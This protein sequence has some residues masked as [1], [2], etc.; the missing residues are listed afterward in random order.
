MSKHLVTMN[1]LIEDYAR[2]IDEQKQE[3]RQLRVALSQIAH[4]V[5][6]AVLPT[7]SLQFITEEVEKEVELVVT[8]LRADNEHLRKRIEKLCKNNQRD[9]FLELKEGIDDLEKRRLKKD[10]DVHGELE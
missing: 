9:F 1:E 5:G 2:I 6:G 7:A 4:I 8:D 3:I 10:L